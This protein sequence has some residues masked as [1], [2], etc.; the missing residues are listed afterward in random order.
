MNGRRCGP[1][2]LEEINMQI[3]YI[4]VSKG[5]EN[6]KWDVKGFNYET[7][8]NAPRMPLYIH[9]L[10]HGI[11][12]NVSGNIEGYYNI[13]LHDSYTY[14]DKPYKYK[15]VLT[16][17][18][19]KDDVDPILIPDPYMIMNWGGS[20]VFDKNGWR[21]KDDKVCFYG[22]TTGDRNPFNNRRI[23]MCLWSLKR[24]DIFDFKITKVAQIREVDI[25]KHVGMDKWRQ[26]FKRTPVTIE[27]QLTHKFHFLPDGNTCKFDVW[28]FK[29]N[30]LNFKDKS[31]EMLWYYPMLCDKE[32]FVETDEHSIESTRMYYLNN[33]G[34]AERIIKNANNLA[35]DLFKPTNHM[36]YTTLLFETMAA[37]GK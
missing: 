31:R 15:D 16:F 21:E 22:T 9:Y 11:F 23:N 37:N 8:D 28:Y 18:K 1:K 10:K 26:I 34:D 12:P 24:P 33:W 25:I 7:H 3:P 14:L 20:T 35:G 36:Y 29:T 6:G 13:E 27:E 5:L 2:R 32:H 4:Y 17:S 19:F 30:T